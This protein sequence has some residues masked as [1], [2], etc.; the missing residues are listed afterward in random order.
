MVSVDEVLSIVTCVLF[1]VTLA[2]FGIR[3]MNSRWGVYSY[4]M[5]FIVLRI[6]GYGIRAYIDSGAI[7]PSNGSYVNLIIT[8]LV[9]LSIGVVFI[10]KL[11]ARLYDFILPKLRSQYSQEPDLFER[12]MVERTRFFLLPLTVLVIVGAVKSTPGH[13][14][15]EMDLGLA[16]RKVGVCLFILLGAWYFYSTF[17]YRNR[18]PANSRAFTIA[19][20]AI[21]LFDISIVYKVVYTFYPAAQN[22]T[23]VYFILSPL[24]ELIVLGVLSVDLQSYFLGYPSADDV[25]IQLV[26]PD[27]YYQSP[28][29]GYYAQPQQQAPP[30]RYQ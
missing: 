19:L 10:M 8:E 5:I 18:Y 26:A 6:V 27:N 25:E 15:S 17:V 2:G 3:F 23:A 1:C 14:A 20:A 13:S 12:C 21:G 30:P 4:I 11:I 7:A 28:P 9:L 29:V 24:L 16:L 22:A